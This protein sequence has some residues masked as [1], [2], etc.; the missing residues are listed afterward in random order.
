MKVPGGAGSSP[1]RQQCPVCS[2][3]GTAV[4][5]TW[6]EEPKTEPHL[7]WKAPGWRAG[8]SPP[9]PEGTR[10]LTK[11]GHQACPFFRDLSPEEPPGLINSFRVPNNPGGAEGR[12]LPCHLQRGRG[13]GAA[14]P[15][16]GCHTTRSE[17]LDS[18]VGW[19]FPPV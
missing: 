9:I 18:G 19:G 11:Q 8:R 13:K 10:G 2:L 4:N 3:C 6:G 7:K 14:G 5:T 17:P 15:A 12:H 16:A 1:P